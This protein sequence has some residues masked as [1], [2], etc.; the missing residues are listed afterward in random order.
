MVWCN[1][2]T[3]NSNLSIGLVNEL[4]NVLELVLS[5]QNE[6]VNDVKTHEPLGKSDHNQI[7]ESLIGLTC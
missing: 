1:I 4:E 3:R 6:L 5:S 2:V 7:Q